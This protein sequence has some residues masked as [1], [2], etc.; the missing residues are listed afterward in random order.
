[1]DGNCLI[2]TYVTN[3]LVEIGILREY[4]YA[5]ELDEILGLEIP[6]C[7]CVVRNFEKML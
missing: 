6:N 4:T 3:Q 2:P 1:M 5:C 7:P